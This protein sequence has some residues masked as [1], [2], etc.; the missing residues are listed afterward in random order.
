MEKIKAVNCI[1]WT[2][3][4]KHGKEE[5]KKR[6]STKFLIRVVCGAF[7]PG[8]DLLKSHHTMLE[9]RF[10]IEVV[11]FCMKKVAPKPDDPL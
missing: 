11:I 4:Y 3:Q 5:R 10:T 2:S 1:I 6:P 9:W 8:Q 7:M